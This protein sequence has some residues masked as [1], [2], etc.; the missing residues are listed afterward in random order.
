MQILSYNQSADEFFVGLTAGEFDDVYARVALNGMSLSKYQEVEEEA[1]LKNDAYCNMI[2]EVYMIEKAPFICIVVNRD[3]STIEV[4]PSHYPFA[5]LWNG[6][7]PWRR[8]EVIEVD[9]LDL[10][11]IQVI[12]FE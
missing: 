2:C 5:N 11:N 4:R 12:Y 7:S 8:I 1:L 6:Y 9:S 10:K 3:L